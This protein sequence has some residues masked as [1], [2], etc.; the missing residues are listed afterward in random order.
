MVDS[1]KESW[2]GENAVRV[3]MSRAETGSLL[4]HTSL[5]VFAMEL[6]SVASCSHVTRLVLSLVSMGC[7]CHTKCK[8]IFHSFICS[9]VHSPRHWARDSEL[10]WG[11]SAHS[12][13]LEEL[14][15]LILSTLN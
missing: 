3:R 2:L 9:F 14:T 4:Y 13:V 1:G 15:V 11:W 6:T 5:P 12:S 8:P 7:L 10:E